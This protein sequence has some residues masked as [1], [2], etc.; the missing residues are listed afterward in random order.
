MAA[1]TSN[2]SDHLPIFFVENPDGTIDT[3]AGADT[4][5]PP[6]TNPQLKCHHCETLLEFTAGASYVQCFICRT[7]NAVLSAQ[8]LGGRTMNMLCTVCGTSNL[9]PWGTEYVRCGQCSTVSDVTH[10]YNMQGSYR[11]PRR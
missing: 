6:Q 11:Q 1:E 5:Q 4:I 3:V 8:Q 10:I 9:A 2:A 7:M